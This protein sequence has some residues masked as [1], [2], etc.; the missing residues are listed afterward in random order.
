MTGFNDAVLD[1]PDQIALWSEDNGYH[2]AHVYLNSI[3]FRS[4]E[5]TFFR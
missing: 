1:L 5:P 2:S 4:T 3:Y